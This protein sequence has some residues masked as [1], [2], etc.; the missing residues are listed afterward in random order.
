MGMSQL[1]LA[2]LAGVDRTMLSRVEGG[3][4]RPSLEFLERCQGVL[5]VSLHRAAVE[6]PGPRL[7][8]DGLRSH[9]SWVRKAFPRSAPSFPPPLRQAFG[10]VRGTQE[11]SLLVERVDRQRRSAAQWAGIRELAGGMYGSEQAFL[12]QALLR[13]GLIQEGEPREVEFPL[14]SVCFPGQRSLCLHLG[15]CIYFPQLTLALPYNGGL[16]PEARG[17]RQPRMDFLV[18]VASRPR[19]FLD[20][21]IYGPNHLGREREDAARARAIGLPQLIVPVA[22]LTGEG[23]W[24]GFERELRAVV[25]REGRVWPRGRR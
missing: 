23:F 19:L 22:G 11:G 6:P 2:E 21:E 8:T 15:P 10:A 7:A 16:D 25:E 9:Y 1:A 14:P 24:R 18:A 3:K 5:G 12:L 20:L 4:V 13:G 17:I